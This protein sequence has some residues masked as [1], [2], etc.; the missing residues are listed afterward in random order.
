MTATTIDALPT[1]CIDAISDA[2][3]RLLLADGDERS[4]AQCAAHL[5]AVCKSPSMFQGM[6]YAVWDRVVDP[7]CMQAARAA[8]K[9][10]AELEADIA[11]AADQ[12]A[13]DSLKLRKL[14]AACR[15]AGALTTGSMD[16]L[17][18][19][20]ADARATRADRAR[21]ALALAPGYGIR[22]SF[23]ACPVRGPARDV[24]DA[25]KDAD[26]RFCESLCR[27]RH[28]LLEHDTANRSRASRTLNLYSGVSRV[29]AR[30][31]KKRDPYGITSSDPDAVDPEVILLAGER[32]EQFG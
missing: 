3:V 24:V 8:A 25:L 4:A 12:A 29:R 7:G 26:A 27:L 13:D 16:V 22:A 19:R 31:V 21:R 18:K 28:A 14:R 10:R 6:A 11:K 30:L 20:L 23:P 1:I 5:M 9:R 32:R 15:A 17:R 2:L